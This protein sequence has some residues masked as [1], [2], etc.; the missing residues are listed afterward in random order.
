[1]PHGTPLFSYVSRVC[2]PA[3]ED[4]SEHHRKQRRPAPLPASEGKS[5]FPSGARSSVNF[6]RISPHQHTDDELCPSRLTIPSSRSRALAPLPGATSHGSIASTS[7]A[8]ME[9]P[10]L[11]LK[12]L[13]LSLN[14][15][16]RLT[17]APSVS[18]SASWMPPNGTKRRRTTRYS[19]PSRPLVDDRRGAYGRLAGA[20]PLPDRAVQPH[21]EC[22]LQ[23]CHDQE[24]DRVVQIPVGQRRPSPSYPSAS[25]LSYS[26]GLRYSG[27]RRAPATPALS[28]RRHNFIGLGAAA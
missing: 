5:T 13:R 27:A 26:V 28:H 21:E 24:P 4:R 19:I 15:N 20:Q 7:L 18:M 6:P 14:A 17:V 8:S 23:W 2:Y 12:V 16:V 9:L 3:G 1:M 22:D 10:T 11:A 25:S